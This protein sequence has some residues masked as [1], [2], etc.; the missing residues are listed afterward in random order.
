MAKAKFE[1]TTDLIKIEEEPSANNKSKIPFHTPLSEK[2]HIKTKEQINLQISG[3]TKK[4]FKI[5]CVKNAI[6]M[7]DALELAIK[8]L[9]KK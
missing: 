3:K 8:E 4:E 5:W 6:H 9:I 2:A 7:S 1:L